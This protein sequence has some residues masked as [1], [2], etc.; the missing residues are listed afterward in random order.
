MPIATAEDWA[1]QNKLREE[2]LEA[3]PNAEYEGWMS[4]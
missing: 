4:I 3:N 2:W 1:Q